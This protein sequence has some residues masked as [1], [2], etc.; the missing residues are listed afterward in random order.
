VIRLVALTVVLLTLGLVLIPA[1][2]IQV[3]T[4]LQIGNQSL[5]AASCATRW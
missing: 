3:P 5:P 1:T 2:A 4:S